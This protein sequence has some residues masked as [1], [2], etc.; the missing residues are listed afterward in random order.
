MKAVDQ[1]GMALIARSLARGHE[2]VAQK[3]VSMYKSLHMHDAVSLRGRFPVNEQPRHALL[4][5]SNTDYPERRGWSGGEG[6][7]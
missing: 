5:R 6:K 7:G 1:S 3:Y 4:F 2:T